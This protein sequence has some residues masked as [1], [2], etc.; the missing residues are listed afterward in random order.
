MNSKV[1]FEIFPTVDPPLNKA[2]V[3]LDDPTP[4][5]STE[6]GDESAPVRPGLYTELSCRPRLPPLESRTAGCHAPPRS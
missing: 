4:P 6:D 1:S 5:T 2:G 3:A